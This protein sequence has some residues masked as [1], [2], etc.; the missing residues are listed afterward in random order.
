[1]QKNQLKKLFFAIAIYYALYLTAIGFQS[2]FWSDILSPIGPLVACLLIFDTYRKL[3]HD[4][5]IHYNWI[6]FCLACLWWVLADTLWA[7]N[8]LFLHENPEFFESILLFYVG[9]NAFLFIGLINHLIFSFRKWNFIQLIVDSLAITATAVFFFWVVFMGKDFHML[10]AI[11]EEGWM[12]TTTIFVD[13]T[14]LIGIMIWYYSIRSGKIPLFLRIL[15]LSLIAFYLTDLVYYYLEIS[16]KYVPNSMIDAIYVLSFLGLAL[17]AKMQPIKKTSFFSSRLSY[18]NLGTHRKSLL[19][20]LAPTIVALINGFVLSDTLIFLFIILIYEALT[21]YIQQSI[22]EHA[23]NLDLEDLVSERTK[24][25]VEKNKQLDFLS[26]QDIVTNLFN[27]RYF[28]EHLREMISTLQTGETLA[29]LYI[30]VDR[31]KTINDTYGHDVGDEVL[32]KIAKRIEGIKPDSALLSRFGGDEFVLALHTNYGYQKMELLAQIIIEECS[33]AI[34]V[35]HY[36]FRLSVS[37]GIAIYPLDAGSSEMLIK[38]A[39]MA[40]YQ[41]KRQSHKNYLSFNEELNQKIQRK[42]TIE[43]LLKQ[44]D[45]D[46]EFTLYFQPQFQVPE[47]KLVGME[48]LLRWKPPGLDFIS[49]S[50]FIPIAEEMDYIIPIGDWVMKKAIRQINT[51]NRNYHSNL[52]MGI[53]VSAKQLYQTGFIKEM[54]VF[55]RK[56]GVAPE[57]VDIELTEGVAMDPGSHIFDVTRHFKR[58]GVSISIDD[59]GTGYSSLAN[60]K[61]FPF[62]RIKIA[63]PLINAITADDYDLY[64][65]KYTVLLAKSLGIKTIA[66]GVETK[67]QFDVLCDL[68]CEEIQGFYLGKPVP[69]K[70]FEES[71]LLPHSPAIELTETQENP[72]LSYEESLS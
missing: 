24:E 51:W 7:V 2:S 29:L 55:M 8:A 63:K 60:L 5:I 39:D 36:S 58:A 68:G 22:R 27:R 44:A 13:I 14:A 15:S 66:E 64:I 33:A 18:S 46:K 26:N 43:I 32:I 48:A 70:D 72:I 37:I 4:K 12:T 16:G 65:T 45:F 30:D 50:E 49:P 21:I 3:D 56:Y 34:H 62:D 6:F 40:M 35:G 20:L 69:A 52:K 25:L 28:T 23:L 31:F 42:N 61:L 54:Q 17:G 38:N 57:W 9:T 1:M 41:A 71:F 19:L 10:F 11:L 59:F 47:T 67:A 53:N